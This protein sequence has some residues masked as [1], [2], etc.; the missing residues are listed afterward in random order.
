MISPSSRGVRATQIARVLFLSSLLAGLAHAQ[1]VNVT[2]YHYDNSLSG[3]N[4]QETILTPSNVKSLTFGKLFSV[5]TDGV[6]Y[7]QPLYLTGVSIAGGTHNV[8]YVADEHDSVYAID[9]DS[10]TVYA[11][12]SLTPAG[13][14]TVSGPTDLGCTDVIP[15]VGITGTPV[16]DT[17]TNTLYVVAVNKNADASFSQYLHALDITT[18][19]E[20][21]GG[22]VAINA[23]VAG[24]ASDGNGSTVT[25]NTKLAFQRAGLMLENHGLCAGSR[26]RHR[27]CGGLRTGAGG[28]AEHHA[29]RIGRRPVDVGRRSC[30]RCQRQYLFP[31]R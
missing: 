26:L 5:A 4:T 31:D 6:V 8:V 13:G 12:V 3:A 2:T 30:E 23:S 18:L 22:P 7:A 24:T 25:F 11:Q 20:K 16:I 9:A 10:G 14:S 29:Q 21:F 15:E 28:S 19:A 1:A 27:L 17:G